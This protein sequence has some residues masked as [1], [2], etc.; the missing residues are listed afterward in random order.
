MTMALNVNVLVLDV[1]EVSMV[2]INQDVGIFEETLSSAL[3]DS[4]CAFIKRVNATRSNNVDCAHHDV[5]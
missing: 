4:I 1:L 2:A 3:P 5:L